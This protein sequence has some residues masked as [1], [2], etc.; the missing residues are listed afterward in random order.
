M[1]KPATT[2]VV[3]FGKHLAPTDR[4]VIQTWAGMALPR[5]GDIQLNLTAKQ[6]EGLKVLL[7]VLGKGKLN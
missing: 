5:S 7:E 4:N 2:P 1:A 3:I 6:A